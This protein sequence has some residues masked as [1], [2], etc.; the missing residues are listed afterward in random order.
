ML[1]FSIILC[2]WLFFSFQELQGKVDIFVTTQAELQGKV[3]ALESMSMRAF[4][5]QDRRSRCEDEL[6]RLTEEKK[7]CVCEL[8]AYTIHTVGLFTDTQ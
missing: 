4:T 3:A 6:R 8:D 5:E 7:V 1:Q 2:L